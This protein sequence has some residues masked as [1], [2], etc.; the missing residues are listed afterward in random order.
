MSYKVYYNK[1]PYKSTPAGTAGSRSPATSPSLVE[2]EGI[3]PRGQG[4]EAPPPSH[5]YGEEAKPTHWGTT[6][7]GEGETT[8]GAWA[9][10]EEDPT[11][12]NEDCCDDDFQECCLPFLCFLM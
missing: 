4:T 3:A 10:D 12:N 6:A 8:K 7:G 2:M 5:D 9:G 1:S 11:S